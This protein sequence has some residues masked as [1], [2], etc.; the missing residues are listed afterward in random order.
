MCKKHN[1]QYLIQ[2]MQNNEQIQCL[3][4]GFSKLFFKI[5][6]YVIET[7]S[8]LLIQ[9]KTLFF[10]KLQPMKFDR[11]NQLQINSLFDN[12]HPY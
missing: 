7:Q 8:A 3:F 5:S 1:F 10:L 12:L 2:L 4:F 11:I 6:L 9:E